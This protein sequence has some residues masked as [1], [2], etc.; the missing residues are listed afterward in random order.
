MDTEKRQESVQRQSG[1]GFRNQIITQKS[2]V[3]KRK[4]A[5]EVFKYLNILQG[6]SM[7]YIISEGRN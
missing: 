7:F 1:E 5:L 2:A 3:R 4:E 6:I